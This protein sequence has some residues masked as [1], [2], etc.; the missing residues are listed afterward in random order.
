MSAVFAGLTPV[1]CPG[2]SV[3]ETLVLRPAERQISLH[4]DDSNHGF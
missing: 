3:D 2:V 1:K 4:F